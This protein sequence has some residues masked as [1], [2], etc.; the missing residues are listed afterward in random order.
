MELDQ[1]KNQAK[2]SQL[3]EK[4]SKQST[5]NQAIEKE[6]RN[7]VDDIENLRSQ[8]QQKDLQEQNLIKKHNEQ[9]EKFKKQVSKKM[10]ETGI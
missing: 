1:D 6:T 10:I 7:K 8:L 5:L 2:V 9:L 3:E 4:L